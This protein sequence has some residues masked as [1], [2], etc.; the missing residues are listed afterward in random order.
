VDL[1]GG[2]TVTDSKGGFT[3]AAGLGYIYNNFEIGAR[4]QS[5]TVDGN[6]SSL[7][8]IHIGYNFFLSPQK[9]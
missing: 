6:S 3:W 5:A 1:E 7:V 9:K 4:Y 8:G 2:S